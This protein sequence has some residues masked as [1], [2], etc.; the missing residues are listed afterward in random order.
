MADLLYDTV[1]LMD[2]LWK[3]KEEQKPYKMKYFD[4]SEKEKNNEIKE[5]FEL[6]LKQMYI[7]CIC[8]QCI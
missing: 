1:K 2:K 7:I 8:I 4:E 5:I 3:I 6:I